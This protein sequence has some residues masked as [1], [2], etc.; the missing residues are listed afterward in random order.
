M[1]NIEIK[2]KICDTGK[3]TINI[4]KNIGCNV[5]DKGKEIYVCKY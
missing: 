5:V 4:L 2:Q 1:G 3:G